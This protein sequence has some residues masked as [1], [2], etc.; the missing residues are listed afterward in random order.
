[1]VFYTLDV[2]LGLLPGAQPDA[3]KSAKRL[4]ER[5]RVHKGQ[6]TEIEAVIPATDL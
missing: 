4:G 3:P 5:F 2:D 1:M 6:I